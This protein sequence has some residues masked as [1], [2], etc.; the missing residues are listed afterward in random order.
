MP[1]GVDKTKA[2]WIQI[3]REKSAFC[4]RLVSFFKQNNTP[5]KRS[6]TSLFHIG[7]QNYFHKIHIKNK[8]AQN[9]FTGI[10]EKG[11]RKIRASP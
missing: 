2:E 4:C 8:H 1:S 9:Q 6:I 3:G 10:N 7:Y 5:I 11:R